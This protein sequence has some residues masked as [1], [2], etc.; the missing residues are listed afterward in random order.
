MRA[1]GLEA[2]NETNTA[3]IIYRFLTLKAEDVFINNNFVQRN[4]VSLMSIR[5]FT[6]I[7][8]ERLTN[9]EIA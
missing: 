5:V 8:N 1:I 9:V 6:N 2:C 7:A 4:Q 3:Q